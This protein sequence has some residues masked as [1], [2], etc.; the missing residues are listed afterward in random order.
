MSQVF[1]PHHRLQLFAAK[2]LLVLETDDNL[3]FTGP[4]IVRIF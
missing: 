4:Y 3:K 2:K 1:P